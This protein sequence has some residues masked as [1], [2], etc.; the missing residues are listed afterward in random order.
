MG[1][2]F[3]L[4]CFVRRAPQRVLR[5]FYT[6]SRC[7]P[8]NG[9]ACRRRISLV[10]CLSI[11]VSSTAGGQTLPRGKGES[12]HLNGHKT[13]QQGAA[14]DAGRYRGPLLDSSCAAP[15]SFVFAKEKMKRCFLC[16]IIRYGGLGK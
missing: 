14:V 5:H 15:L 4:D 11:R 12:N 7:I 16:D 1:C 6:C 3:A 8:I 13:G 9:K 2:S 10:W